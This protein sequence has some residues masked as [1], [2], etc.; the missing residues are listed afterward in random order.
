M[1]A[2]QHR[3]PD[4]D[5]ELAV[6]LVVGD[7]DRAVGFYRDLLGA[8]V[9]TRWDTYARLTLGRGT[10]HLATSSAETDD[11]PG[12]GL[13]PPPDPAT[14]S[15]ELVI[16][17]ADCHRVHRDLTDRGVTFLAPPSEPPWGGEVRCF[18]QDPDGHLIEMSQTTG[19]TGW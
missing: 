4:N 11:K 9:L 16:H 15:S 10:L 19:E 12:I 1:T 14:V 3:F 6:L 5:A 7:L 8:T 18:L 17:V 13:A 2:D